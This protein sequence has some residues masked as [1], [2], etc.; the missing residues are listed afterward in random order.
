MNWFADNQIS[1]AV[2]SSH[3]LAEVLTDYQRFY[4]GHGVILSDPD[5]LKLLQ[6]EGNV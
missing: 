1:T 5:D 2:L 6:Y 3:Q 4:A